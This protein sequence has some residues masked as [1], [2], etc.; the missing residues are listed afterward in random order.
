MLTYLYLT[1]GIDQAKVEH[2]LSFG[3]LEP[4]I[5]KAPYYVKLIADWDVWT[6]KYGD[7]TRFFQAAINSYD[8]HPEKEFW[9]R[10]DLWIDE[11]QAVIKEGEAMTRFRDGWAK[12]YLRKF[13]FVTEFE[14][15]NC[16]ALNIQHCNSEYFKSVSPIEFDAFIAFSYNGDL[17]KVSMYAAKQDVDV[18]EICK[19]YGGGGHKGAAGFAAER[20]PFKKYR[21]RQYTPMI[22]KYLDNPQ[23]IVEQLKFCEYKSSEGGKLEMNV[24]FQALEKLVQ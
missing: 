13:G 22:E 5:E 21:E 17:F 14:G 3:N 2:S 8:A 10:L 15:L 6:F 23:E 18:S 11:E 9:H 24:A 7:Q 12:D 16:I 4:W 1:H 19:K 20:L